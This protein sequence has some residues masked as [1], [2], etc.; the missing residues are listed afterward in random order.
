MVSLG[1]A[2]VVRCRVSA[3]ELSSQGIEYLQL[4]H[5]GPVHLLPGDP[6][7]A[8][9]VRFL[10]RFFDLHVMSP[11]QHAVSGAL[12]GDPVRRQE[13]LALAE[14]K[15][16]LAY[17]WLEGQLTGRIWAA[18]AD[19]TLADCAAAPALFYADW[20][21]R[22]SEAFPVLRAYRARLLGRPSF[23]R[24]VE[25]ARPFRPLT[26]AIKIHCNCASF[27]STAS[28]KMM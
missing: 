3:K 26:A 20:T 17:A 19:F 9:D 11:V 12:T 8:L 16:E 15:L 10:D 28:S 24:A 5:P 23:A 13:G 2:V 4:V 14:Q 27:A 6:M 25:K 22:I 7:A 18:G 1:Q 21:H